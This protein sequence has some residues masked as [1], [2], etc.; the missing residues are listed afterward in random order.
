MRDDVAGLAKGIWR[1]A[2][3]HNL[4]MSTQRGLQGPI[5]TP[6]PAP[7]QGHIFA[8]A[9]LLAFSLIARLPSTTIPVAIQR[10][11]LCSQL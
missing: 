1:R 3:S 4:S 8:H 11:S 9:F 10:I 5:T 6:A 7:A 2:R